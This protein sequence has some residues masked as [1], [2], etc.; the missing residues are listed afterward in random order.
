MFNECFDI[1]WGFY[2]YFEN[3][4]KFKM[5]NLKIMSESIFSLTS[6]MWKHLTNT[7]K[8][9]FE[10]LILKILIIKSWEAAIIR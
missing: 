7:L 5:S 9:Y 1:A 8:L 4:L 6:S 2:N 3:H 10:F